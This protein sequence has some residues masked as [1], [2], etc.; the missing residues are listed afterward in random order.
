V[1]DGSPEREAAVNSPTPQPHALDA[2]QESEPFFERGRQFFC[3]GQIAEGSA[4]DLKAGGDQR[5]IHGLADKPVKGEPRP[6]VVP[7]AGKEQ[8]GRQVIGQLAIVASA[9]LPQLAQKLTQLESDMIAQISLLRSEL[10]SLAVGKRIGRT[11]NA[12]EE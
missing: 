1:T 6:L 10:G 12:I 3:E 4:F 7:A 5:A 8:G 11:E 2:F 9:I